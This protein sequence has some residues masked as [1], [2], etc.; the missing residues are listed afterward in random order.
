MPVDLTP[1]TEEY[2]CKSD[3][4]LGTERYASRSENEDARSGTE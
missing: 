2:A 1:W 4:R 3:T